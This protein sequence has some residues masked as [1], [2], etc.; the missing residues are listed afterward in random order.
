MVWKV[1]IIVIEGYFGTACRVQRR[2]VVIELG[3]I[4][5][6]VFPAEKKRSPYNLQC[7]LRQAPRLFRVNDA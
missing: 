7:A 3:I 5:A 1:I 2:H 4:N 6:L